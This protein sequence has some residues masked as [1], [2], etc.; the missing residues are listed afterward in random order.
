M[1]AQASRTRSA[2]HRAGDEFGEL[3]RAVTAMALVQRESSVHVHVH[4][5]IVASSPT[6]SRRGLATAQQFR[7][8]RHTLGGHRTVGLVR[9]VARMRENI[10]SLSEDFGRFGHVLQFESRGV[11]TNF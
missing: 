5:T 2:L 3:R 8:V 1:S 6:G 10:P 11:L 4:V 7:R 9:V